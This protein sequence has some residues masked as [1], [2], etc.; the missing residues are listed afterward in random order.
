MSK[1]KATKLRFIK[2][3]QC[4]ADGRPLFET[5]GDSVFDSRQKCAMI[6]YRG[7]KDALE[8]MREEGM[9]EK[10]FEIIEIE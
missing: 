9:T 6:F 5:A 2:W 4:H 7:E 3:F 10:R 8:Q 1:S